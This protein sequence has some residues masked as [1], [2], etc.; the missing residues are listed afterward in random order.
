M[1]IDEQ[2]MKEQAN[3]L[4]DLIAFKAHPDELDIRDKIGFGD[5][6]YGR[7]AYVTRKDVLSVLKRVIDG[8]L[9]FKD[10]YDWAVS[11]SGRSTIGYEK[12]YRDI[13]ADLL[14]EMIMLYESRSANSLLSEFTKEIFQ[15]IQEAKFDA[16][17]EDLDA[18]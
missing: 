6:E 16:N 3:Y 4:N 15:K 17:E 9:T 8:K 1:K 14:D 11:I 2:F 12:G 7:L 13:L 5:W 10:F 18:D